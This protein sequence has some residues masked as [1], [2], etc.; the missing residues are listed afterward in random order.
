[1]VS[2]LR[3]IDRR[4]R[5]TTRRSRP[6]VPPQ[7]ARDADPGPVTPRPA[8]APPTVAAAV[9]ETGTDG[10]ARWTFPTPFSRPP[11]LAA[12]PV[13]PNPADDTGTFM[14]TLETVDETYA[15]LRVWRTGVPPAV[16]GIEPAGAGIH[17]HLTAT[18]T[19]A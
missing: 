4:T 7:P 8:P 6:A 5:S 18:P 9:V 10:R 16:G 14:A 12:L 3:D 2:L 11:A 13:D 1:M 17:V 19:T 15:E